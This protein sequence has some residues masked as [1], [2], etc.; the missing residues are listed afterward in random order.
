MAQQKKIMFLGGISYIIPA[1]NV[2]HQLGYYVIT[3]DYLPNNPAHKYA[4]EYVNVSIIDKDAVLE[5]AKSKQID[6]ILSF[7]V[8]PGVVTAAYV[9]EKLGLTNVGPYKSVEILQDKTLFR[10][11][12]LENGFNVPISKGYDSIDNALKDTNWLDFPMIVKPADGSGSKGVTRVDDINKYKQALEIAFSKS[13]N[14]KVVVEKFIELD[15]YQSGSDCF[16]VEGKLIYASFDDQYFDRKA[17][18]PYTPSAHTWPSTMSPAHQKYLFDE[19]QRLLT[20]LEMRTSLY[21]IEVRVGKDGKPYIMEVSPRAGGNRLSEILSLATGV[22]LVRASV[23][24][25]MG[26]AVDVKPAKYD[27]FWAVI[28]LH[29]YISGI[30]QKLVV[31][32]SISQNIIKTNLNI[33][34]GD[35]VEKFDC[36]TNSI[37]SLFMRFDTREDLNHFLVHQDELVKVIVA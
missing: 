34:I 7:A 10:K 15:G 6:G 3:A 4:D 18:N 9:A 21:N 22:D 1:I 32:N 17:N 16:S 11:F 33:T 26:E 20:L 13:I 14:K 30:F 31:D 8:D 29:S 2:A 35:S 37:G 23:L 12:L 28:V 25:A 36:A 5:I 24:S 27:G 19:L